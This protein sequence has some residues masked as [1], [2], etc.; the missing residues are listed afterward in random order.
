MSHTRKAL[1]FSLFFVSGIA[2][3]QAAGPVA[4]SISTPLP[5]PA[6]PGNNPW[7]DYPTHYGPGSVRQHGDDLPTEA[8][9]RLDRF[10]A[11]TELERKAFI[12]QAERAAFKRGEAL[13]NDTRLGTTGLN[14]AACHP[15]GGTAGGKVGMGRHEVEIATLMNVADRY[16]GYKP[17]DGRVITQSEMQN[18]CIRMF[19]KGQPLASGT[20]EAADLSLF[21]GRFRTA[22]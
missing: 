5:R 15:N 19:M 17:L 11:L 9:A 6:N 1:L 2:P 4:S 14:C 10:M 13:F 18:N 12:S 8:M 16:P 21:V 3:L 22:R 7:L 20:R